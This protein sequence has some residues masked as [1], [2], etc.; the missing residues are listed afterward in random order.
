[1]STPVERVQ[2]YL[3]QRKM[4]TRD[5]GERIHVTWTDVNADMVALTI[6]DLEAALAQAWDEGGEAAIEREH[7]YGAAEK[8][9]FANPY[10]V[11][12]VNTPDPT[13]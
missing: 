3:R 10:R 4:Q 13:S 2:E 11:P 9:K 5:L 12:A 1:M 7:T 8:A 6:G